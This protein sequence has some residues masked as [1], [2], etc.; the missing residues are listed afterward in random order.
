MRSKY[1]Y[2]YFTAKGEETLKLNKVISATL[3]LNPLF[4]LSTLI[5]I[6]VEGKHSYLKIQRSY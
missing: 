5:P 6:E 1:V 4:D 3:R 2:K